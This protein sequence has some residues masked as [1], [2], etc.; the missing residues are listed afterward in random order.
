MRKTNKNNNDNNKK[1]E[2]RIEN[3]LNMSISKFGVKKTTSWRETN[4]K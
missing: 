2:L 3:L 1:L 4:Q